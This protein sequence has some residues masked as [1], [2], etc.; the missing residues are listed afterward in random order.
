MSGRDGRGYVYLVHAVGTAW[1]KIGKSG[2]PTTRVEQLEKN[3]PYHCRLIHSIRV[4]DMHDTET[5]LHGFFYDK[6]V[7]REWFVLSEEDVKF[8]CRISGGSCDE[9][10]DQIA[11]MSREAK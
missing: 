3:A 5:F 2:D 1:Y 7:K 11:R 10:A 6:V 4:A 8:F 9:V